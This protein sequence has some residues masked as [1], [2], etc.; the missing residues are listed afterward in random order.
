MRSRLCI[1]P[2]AFYT[3]AVQSARLAGLSG[4]PGSVAARLV[5]QAIELAQRIFMYA[6]GGQLS[7][8]TAFWQRSLDRALMPQS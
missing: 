6:F 7:A 1:Y 5:L 4:C 2:Q 3:S 8:H